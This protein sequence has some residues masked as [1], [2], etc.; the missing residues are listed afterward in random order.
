MRVLYCNKYNFPFSGTEVYL[1]QLMAM[2]RSHGQETALFSMAD[3]RGEATPYDR[4]FVPY[5]DFKCKENGPWERLKLGTHAIYSVDARHRLRNVI[6]EFKPDVAHVRNIY[7]HLSPSILWELKAHGV[8]VVYHIN[9]FKMLCPTYNLVSNGRSCEDCAGGQFWRVV[10]KGCYQGPR[11][12]AFVLAVE[13]YVHKW[14]DTYKV[15]VD[16]LLAP[17]QF[18][19]EKFVAAGWDSRRIDVL[20]HFQS[21]ASATPPR[22]PVE[23]PVLYFGRLSP[24]KGVADLV[25]A[26][27]T[28]PHLRLQIAGDGPER[29]ELE[30]LANELRL[31]N[32][33][34]L[35][36]LQ[37][38]Q[39]EQAITD[40]QFTV[41]PSHAYETFGKSI[42]ESFALKRPV[43]A[44]DLG[45]RREL[46]REG[47]TGLLFQPGDIYELKR[48]VS[49]LS[50]RPDFC[51]H[52]GANAYRVV[53]EKYTPEGHYI[54]ISRI[55]ESVLS[56]AAYLRRAPSGVVE[57]KKLR[58]AFIGARG[59]VSKYSGIETYYEEVGKRLAAMGHEVTAYC[60][61][62]FTPAQQEHEGIHLV[63]LP[64]IR[65][66]HFETFVHTLL[67]TVHAMSKRYDVVH[68]HALGP[69]LFSLLPRM[70][71]KKT[72]VTVQGLDWQRKKWGWFA[73]R[74]LRFGESAAACFPSATMVVSQTLRRHYE[75]HGRKVIYV[76]NGTLIRQRRSP[77]YLGPWGLESDK[78]VLF[79]G[80]F[81][82]EKN[83]HLLIEAFERIDTPAK[84]VLAGGAS[85][86]AAYVGALRR[87]ESKRIVFLDWVAGDALDEL[88][89]HAA[90]FVL[91][92]DL[93]GLSLSLLDAMAAGTCVLASDVPENEELV[94]GAGF[95]FRRGDVNDL[96]RVLRS[97]LADPEVR[98]T[99][100]R[101][102]L[103]RVREQYLWPGI[104][105]EVERVYIDVL[106]RAHRPS[107]SWKD[108]HA[109]QK[110]ATRL[111]EQTGT[112]SYL[113]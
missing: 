1:F 38:P 3:P 87:H 12:A 39:L 2:M 108:Q 100:A 113:Q 40:S 109:R 106:D 44:T 62:H 47:E 52:M 73:S 4:H 111:Q 15:C 43:V 24:E 57:R 80:R 16:R 84:L 6:E 53:G 10:T 27:S 20:A 32:V 21:V 71:G 42:L 45:S 61:T 78:Y 51:A 33:E 34:F 29:R 65:T 37:G 105:S 26:F 46:V 85:H 56:Q 79:L 95:T 101:A 31:N 68:Y 99:A 67:S 98:G 70:V 41:L 7:H 9:D 8:P 96:E 88:L 82:P 66:K 19:K 63:R 54:G 64:T 94:A 90:L 23:G 72:L 28:L 97:L 36:H 107:S 30:K 55:Y 103:Q 69:A 83:C 92:S 13:A 93:E 76:P 25:R 50:Q 60:R 77:V 110:P 11:S 18:V 112:K 22:S 86:S 17:S 89:T 59:V 91:P 48:A 14:L 35:G 58:I 81:S 49:F 74:V 102:A 104:A 75:A 5:L